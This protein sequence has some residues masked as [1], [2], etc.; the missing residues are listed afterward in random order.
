[1][2][3]LP[4]L[5][6]KIEDVLSVNEN[7]AHYS[8]KNSCMLTEKSLSLFYICVK[9]QQGPWYVGHCHHFMGQ[10]M[11]SDGG[12]RLQTWRVAVG[13]GRKVEVF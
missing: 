4:F 1:M 13:S 2:T 7:Y 9:S 11:V 12:G 3:C 6:N 10:P 8:V 5:Y